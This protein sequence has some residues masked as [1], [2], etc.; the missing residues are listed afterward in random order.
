MNRI[1][2]VLRRQK[3]K[4]ILKA[5]SLNDSSSTEYIY[6][7]LESK[8]RVALCL[9]SDV[10]KEPMNIDNKINLPNNPSAQNDFRVKLE[11]FSMNG[12]DQ[13][14]FYLDEDNN[15][16]YFKSIFQIRAATVWVAIPT[17]LYEVNDYNIEL[18]MDEDSFPI[19]SDY[20]RLNNNGDLLVN[21][22]SYILSSTDLVISLIKSLLINTSTLGAVKF[23]VSSKYLV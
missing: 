3:K 7:Y 4:I 6:D 8:N 21:E 13:C 11:P 1:S 12:I 17:A 10:Y 9:K 19:I 15:K 16:L 22:Y 2:L 18:I 14:I 5:S 20:T 23:G